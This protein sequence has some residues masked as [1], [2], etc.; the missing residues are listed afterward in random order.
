MSSRALF[1]YCSPVLLLNHSPACGV[2]GK[3]SRGTSPCHTTSEEISLIPQKQVKD[4]SGFRCGKP[5]LEEVPFSLKECCNK[6]TVSKPNVCYCSG[7]GTLLTFVEGSIHGHRQL[8]NI[9][10]TLGIFHLFCGQALQLL[11]HQ[12]TEDLIRVLR[13]AAVPLK[14]ERD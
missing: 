14:K 5:V 13:A 7:L 8:H 3:G 9:V 1:C 2:G 4:Q 12:K 10:H 6:S 11:L